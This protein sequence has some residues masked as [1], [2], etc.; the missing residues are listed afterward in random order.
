[1]NPLKIIL[2]GCGKM[3]KEAEAVALERGHEIALKLDVDNA[4][5]F[6]KKIFQKPILP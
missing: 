2:I 6:T 5:D 4:A 3:G 1:M